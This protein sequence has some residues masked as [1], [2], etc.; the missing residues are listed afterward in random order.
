MKNL[1]PK[2][3]KAWFKRWNDW[4]VEHGDSKSQSKVQV[5]AN[6]WVKGMA[7]IKGC[8]VDDGKGISHRV[9]N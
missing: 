2:G 6:E 1:R 7:G 9:G 4:E 5:K 8:G 3:A